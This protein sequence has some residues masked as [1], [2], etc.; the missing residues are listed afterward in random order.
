MLGLALFCFYL[1]APNPTQGYDFGPDGFVYQ[2]HPEKKPWHKASRT[3]GADGGRLAVI[4]SEV[5]HKSVVSLFGNKGVFWFGLSDEKKEGDWVWVNGKKL[6]TAY[7]AVNQPDNYWARGGQDCALFNWGGIGRWDDQ[8]CNLQQL[9]FLCQKMPGLQCDADWKN[10]FGEN[11]Q[12]YGQNSWCKKSGDHYGPAWQSQWET[13]EKWAD[14]EGRTALVCPQC[15]CEDAGVEVTFTGGHAGAS[16]W[17]SRWSIHAPSSAFGKNSPAPGWAADFGQHMA[18]NQVVYYQFNAPILVTRFT[19]GN[20][21]DGYINQSPTKIQLVGNN[22]A[23][24]RGTSSWQTVF[25][26][27]DFDFTGLGQVKMWDVPV[28]Q[29][30]VFRCWGIKT[31]KTKGRGPTIRGI[32]MW[33]KGV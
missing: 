7:W 16:S 10:G 17:A 21:A 29:E 13:F 15:G 25:E 4:D 20:R 32:R 8:E 19:I 6:D 1:C 26:S 11:C 18:Y 12:M 2:Y 9:P 14:Q 24:C 22:D 33:K 3:C 31:L 30:Q 28:A 27:P 23:D 5:I